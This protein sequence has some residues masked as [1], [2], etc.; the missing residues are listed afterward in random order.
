MKKYLKISETN[1]KFIIKMFTLSLFIKLH[2]FQS[3]Q[4]GNTGVCAACPDNCESCSDL[5]KC[6]RCKEGYA[7]SMVTS[8]CVENCE[9]G[10]YK[11]LTG[12]HLTLFY[13]SAFLS[14]PL[15]SVIRHIPS[16]HLQKG[17]YINMHLLAGKSQW[18]KYFKS[19]V[20]IATGV[21]WCYIRHNCLHCR[22]LVFERELFHAHCH[23]YLEATTKP[24]VL[25]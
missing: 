22:L 15:V 7:V 4:N 24:A 1:F 9:F 18:I 23:V 19:F 5:S 21:K 2:T 12:I 11:P 10:F 16:V 3:L 13:L 17:D 25:S 14:S 20:T 8:K 6:N